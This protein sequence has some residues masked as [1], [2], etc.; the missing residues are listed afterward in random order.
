MEAQKT[1]AKLCAPLRLCEDFAHKSDR[2]N[3]SDGPA[4]PNRDRQGAAPRRQSSIHT[5]EQSKC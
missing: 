4:Q 3:T 5:Q 2:G 1:S